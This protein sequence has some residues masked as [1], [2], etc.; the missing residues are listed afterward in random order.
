MR[1]TSEGGLTQCSWLA[2]PNSHL[3]WRE[4]PPG[5]P[6]LHKTATE[7]A[8]VE[9]R[10][11][12]GPNI[13]GTSAGNREDR[14]LIGCHC[15]CVCEHVHGWIHSVWAEAAHYAYHLGTERLQVQSPVQRG[16]RTLQSFCP[17]RGLVGSGTV[18]KIWPMELWF[19]HSQCDGRK[20]NR[21]LIVPSHTYS[22]ALKHRHKHK[23]VHY[24]YVCVKL[25]KSI[26]DRIDRDTQRIACSA[27]FLIYAHV[28]VLS[29][30]GWNTLK[31][32]LNLS[33]F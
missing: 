5:R 14:K 24:M 33:W 28:T 32:F 31:Y 21:T 26:K 19:R 30:C 8:E 10:T 27:N 6:V 15:L 3:R 4:C 9:V 29:G 25:T 1:R 13:V 20:Q 17:D 2:N 22:Y 7:S 11:K 23:I 12:W 16:E 18:C